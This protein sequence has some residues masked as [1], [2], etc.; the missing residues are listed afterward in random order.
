[1]VKRIKIIFI[2]PTLVSFLGAVDI[3]KKAE[4]SY[5]KTSG[6][7]NTSS[8]YGKLGANIKN[9]IRE[10]KLN[11]SI[12]KSEDNHKKSA[13]K[14]EV[15]LNYNRML[16]QSVYTYMGAY[17]EKDE[18]SDYSSRFNIGPGLGYKAINTDEEALEVQAGLYYALD[19]FDNGRRD[20]YA[21]PSMELSYRYKIRENVEFKQVLKYLVS[22]EEVSRY[23]IT[24]DSAIAVKMMENLSLG[25]SYRIDYVNQTEK[26]KTDKKFMTS[27]IFDF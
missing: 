26:E 3:H 11:G 17:Y 12:L 25:V 16:T 13:N 15:E 20:D 5:V 4:I 21:A 10:I 8:L 2:L 7:T 9:E 1:M 22:A 23:F 14:Y 24:S 18:F 27:L 6:N 19:K